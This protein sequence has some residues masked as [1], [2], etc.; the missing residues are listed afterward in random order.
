MVG[1]AWA[2]GVNCST[3][4]HRL[5]AAS[6]RIQILVP[7]PVAEWLKTQAEQENRTLSRYTS[8]VLEEFVAK[9]RGAEAP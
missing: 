1:Q 2:S 8:L 4:L 5:M 7:P 3:I 6:T 9:A